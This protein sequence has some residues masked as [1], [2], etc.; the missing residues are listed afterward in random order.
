MAAGGVPRGDEARGVEIVLPGVFEDPAQSAETVLN[1]GGG[2]S[3][4]R[5]AVFDIDHI[6]THLKEG[7]E[8]V[9]VLLLGR[10][11]SPTAAMNLDKRGVGSGGLELI[12]SEFRLV[13]VGGEVRDIGVIL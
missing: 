9:G 1:G 3:Y 4:C 11:A 12:D 7:E 8:L 6:P 5:G 2:E 10:T 13:A